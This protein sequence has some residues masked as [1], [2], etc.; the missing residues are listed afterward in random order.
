MVDWINYFRPAVLA[1]FNGGDPYAF[2]VFNPPWVFAPL[3]PFAL[4]PEPLGG[5]L[6]LAI[7]IFCVGFTI[8]RLGGRRIA[9][10][11]ILLSPLV[12]NSLVWG[13]V[14]WLALLGLVVTPWLGLIL[15]SLKPQITFIAIALIAIQNRQRPRIFVPLVIVFLAS[16]LMFGLYPLRV[17]G[18]GNYAASFN[19]S[20]FPFS[21]PLGF[22]LAYQ[23]LR[24]QKLRNAIA[25]SPLFAPTLS[26]S[27]WAGLPLALTRHPK[28]ALLST[29]SLWAC[30][31]INGSLWQF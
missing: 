7:A 23:S 26:Q 30:V 24:S 4:L 2:A 6:V 13:N 17:L 11:A 16:L 3:I 19:M 21:V 25:A 18:Y 27:A 14:E 15:L 1:L 8:Y 28:L 31:A 20:L 12:L 22:I 10:V 5:V 9:L 29:L